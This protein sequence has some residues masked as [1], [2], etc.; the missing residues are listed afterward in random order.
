MFPVRSFD[1]RTS[2]ASLGFTL[3]ELLVVMVLLG[4]V[5]GIAVTSV[6][7]GNQEK[8]LRNEASRLHALLRMAAE[9][10][11]FSN[12]E[13][14]AYIDTEYYEFLVYDEEAANWTPAPQSFLKKRDL[15]DW[16][17]I[18]YQREGE[19]KDVKL[20]ARSAEGESEGSEQG[21]KKPSF[22]LLSSGE[23]TPFTVAMEV[24]GNPDSR[25]EIKTDENVEI[26][27]LGLGQEE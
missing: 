19:R 26:V 5:A 1:A 10:A 4:L 24:D 27:L 21:G 23:V 20:G 11:V 25:L 13:I 14:G 18:D 6:G 15:P 3:I 2:K 12:T 17:L 7:S 8:E 16:L 22:M 9:E